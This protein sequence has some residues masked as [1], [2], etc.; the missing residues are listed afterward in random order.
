MIEPANSLGLDAFVPGNWEPVYGP[1]QFLSLMGQLKTNVIAYNFHHKSTG[2]R[3]FEPAV[4]CKRDGV[5]V[6][7]VGIADPTTTDRQPPTQVKGLDST[8]IQ[9]LKEYVQELRRNEQT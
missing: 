4:I 3:I 7:F 2:K 1:E 8:R 9:G 6:A 5:R